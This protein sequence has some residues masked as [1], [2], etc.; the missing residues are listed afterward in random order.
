MLPVGIIKCVFIKGEEPDRLT[1]PDGVIT[2][3]F[4][5]VKVIGAVPLNVIP[6]EGFIVK[7]LVPTTGLVPL[8]VTPPVGF[9]ILV[10][11]KLV[12]PLKVIPPVGLIV[13]LEALDAATVHSLLGCALNKELPLLLWYSLDSSALH[14][15]EV[16]PR[17]SI[18]ASISHELAAEYIPILKFLSPA[19]NETGVELQVSP[20]STPSTYNLQDAAVPPDTKT[21]LRFVVLNQDIVPED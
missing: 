4:E 8:N 14:K 9:I 21:K 10:F 1:P 6:P 13:K 3:V 15:A 17:D 11:I 12:V 18:D 20:E 2:Y 5:P 7:L 16:K 19:T